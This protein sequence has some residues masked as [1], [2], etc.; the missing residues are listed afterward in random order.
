MTPI[1]VNRLV[2][3]IKLAALHE[4]CGT[5]RGTISSLKIAAAQSRL[6]TVTG[7]LGGPVAFDSYENGKDE[8]SGFEGRESRRNDDQSGV[9]PGVTH[10]E[11]VHDPEPVSK[12]SVLV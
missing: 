1:L 4:E 6:D 12:A 8:F 3:N 7:D 2:L 11:E 10:V 5:T 9:G